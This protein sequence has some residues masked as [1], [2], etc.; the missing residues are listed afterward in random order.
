MVH[1]SAEALLDMRCKTIL[2]KLPYVIPYIVSLCSSSHRIT[3][4]AQSSNISASRTQPS[5]DSQSNNVDR[6]EAWIHSVLQKWKVTGSY[7]LHAA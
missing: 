6:S 3:P 2:A 1:V 5:Q 4:L 7:R